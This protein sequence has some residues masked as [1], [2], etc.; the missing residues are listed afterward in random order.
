MTTKILSAIQTQSLEWST[1]GAFDVP[2]LFGGG[3]LQLEDESRNLIIRSAEATA[4]S[5]D[6]KMQA[7]MAVTTILFTNVRDIA[8]D[9]FLWLSLLIQNQTIVRDRAKL[10]RLGSSMQDKIF[11]LAMATAWQNYI[12][13]TDREQINTILN[14]YRTQQF[15][16]S[17]AIDDKATYANMLFVLQK[18]N[19]A[20]E[21]F[22]SYWTT[23]QFHWSFS[24][25]DGEVFIVINPDKISQMQEQ[26]KCARFGDKCAGNFKQFV[27]DIETIGSENMQ[28]ARTA[29]KDIVDASGKLKW[30]LQVFG[31]Q[32]A[33]FFRKKENKR[34]FTEEE[35]IALSRQ[36]QLLR[37]V[38]G[39]DFKRMGNMLAVVRMN[40]S[41]ETFQEIYDNMSAIGKS[42]KEIIIDPFNDIDTAKPGTTVT[43]DTWRW[44]ALSEGL[45]TLIM[46]TMQDVHSHGIASIDNAHLMDPGSVM[47]YIPLLSA[48]LDTLRGLIG[49]KDTKG[50]IIYNLGN[51]CELQCSN[52]WWTCR[53]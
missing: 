30:V 24:T 34:A 33:N 35:K 28:A 40:V 1:V 39:S 51:A 46:H 4:R 22:L 50:M 37:T 27:T 45:T 43:I 52:A 32:T 42:F 44:I 20:Y 7:T 26:Y 53:W 12:T 13:L 16:T 36:Q 3:I 48:Q 17:F 41:Q 49:T 31:K 47:I 19:R 21:R 18:M 15:I 5:I 14:D 38:Y 6:Q 23:G 11:E 2:W 25:W 9:N 10:Q 8:R 29:W